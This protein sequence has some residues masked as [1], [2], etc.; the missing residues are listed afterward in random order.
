MFHVRFVR[1]C[2]SPK[3]EIYVYQVIW[4]CPIAAYPEPQVTVSVFFFIEADN[5]QDPSDFVHVIYK[6][7][8]KLIN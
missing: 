2:K 4:S 8:F 6:L 1:L 5:T 3:S 7:M